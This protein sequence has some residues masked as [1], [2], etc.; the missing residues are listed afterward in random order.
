MNKFRKERYI[1]QEQSKR[2]GKWR[3]Q[4]KYKGI[5][6]SFNEDDYLSSKQAFQKAID[7]RNKMMIDPLLETKKT[8]RQIYEEMDDIYVIRSETKRKLDCFFNKYIEKKD[9]ALTDI[10]RADIITD[11]NRMTETCSND[12]IT[13][14]FSIWRKIYQVAIAKEY[15]SRDL[16]Q[17][18]K[19]PTSHR[20][21]PKP[22]LEITDEQTLIT[23][24]KELEKRLKSPLESKQAP[25]MILFLLYTGIR[26]A[27]MFALT[28]DD[29]DLNKKEISI[30][31]E[32]GSDRDGIKVR[33]CKTELSHRVIPIND[34]AVEIIKAAYK[35]TDSNILF[36][37]KNGYYSSKDVG[38]RY[39]QIAKRIGIDFH[40]YQCR[41][42]F[43]TTLYMK[44]V[45]LKT[46]QLLCGQKID[47]TTLGYVVSDRDKMG[48][49]VNLI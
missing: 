45:D 17:Q 1:Y 48:T 37:N 3:F 22:R 36:P 30:Q 38:D 28:R 40:L 33:T 6:K 26:P 29:I 10:T 32:I 23:L 25:L 14:V 5:I 27:E 15:V 24:G 44:G 21:K 43:I 2:T 8:V 42:T 9:F 16:T 34:K 31:R 12:T 49:A 7:F 39:H 18:I 11:L 47:A 20:L 4:V 35:L 19:P 46:I 41:H 13:R